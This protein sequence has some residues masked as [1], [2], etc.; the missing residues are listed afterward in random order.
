MNRISAFMVCLSN[1]FYLVFAAVK[2]GI[3]SFPDIRRGIIILF[4]AE[5]AKKN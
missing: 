2:V 4:P 1:Y 3:F 5:M